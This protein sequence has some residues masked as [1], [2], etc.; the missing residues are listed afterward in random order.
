M[1]VVEWVDS[2]EALTEQEMRG[3]DSPHSIRIERK[4]ITIMGV[5]IP[6]QELPLG[7]AVWKRDIGGAYLEIVC[8]DGFIGILNRVSRDGLR[9]RFVSFNEITV[10]AR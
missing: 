10:P 3:I 6:I 4:P 1:M 7:A 5:I 2:F 8:D 9:Q